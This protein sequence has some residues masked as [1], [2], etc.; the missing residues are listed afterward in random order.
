MLSFLAEL[1]LSDLVTDNSWSMLNTNYLIAFHKDYHNNPDKL[2]PIGIGTAFCRLLARHI[3]H[4]IAPQMAKLFIP[5]GQ[6]AIGASGSM[7]YI[8]H[9]FQQAAETVL[10]EALTFAC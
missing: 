7:D 5:M 8:I 9:F 10:L 1:F 2:R 4:A 3:A 6:F